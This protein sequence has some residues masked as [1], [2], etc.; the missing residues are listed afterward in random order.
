[1]GAGG[2]AG[3]VPPELE[4][5]VEGR[6]DSPLPDGALVK[7]Q[8]IGLVPGISKNFRFV[9]F[10]DGRLFSAVNT[11]E[12]PVDGH[13]RFNVDLPDEPSATVPAESVAQVCDL[14]DSTA[15]ATG[16]AFTGAEGVRDGAV[17]IVTARVDGGVH[18]AWFANTATELTDFLWELHDEATQEPLDLDDL[19]ADLTGQP[20][21]DD[22]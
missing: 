11:S 18:E 21:K 12:P 15:F 13:Q 6:D 19:F 7:F 5:M 20:R 9:L 22:A 14:L 17:I 1:M 8:Y 16:P 4:T 3:G 2:P 10:P